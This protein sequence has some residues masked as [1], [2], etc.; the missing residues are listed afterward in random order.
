MC[1]V[2]LSTG[3]DFLTGIGH[4][5]DDKRQKF[6]LLSETLG[7]LVDAIN[8]RSPEGATETTAPGHFYVWAAPQFALVHALIVI[9]IRKRARLSCNESYGNEAL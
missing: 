5:Y 4:M 7:M 1:R 8:Q 3:I 9:L 6:I 2:V